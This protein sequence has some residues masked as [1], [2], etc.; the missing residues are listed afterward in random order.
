MLPFL[1]VMLSGILAFIKLQSS[2]WCLCFSLHNVHWLWDCSIINQQKKVFSDRYALKHQTEYWAEK[3]FTHWSFLNISKN[4]QP[5]NPPFPHFQTV[6]LFHLAKLRR[7]FVN[8]DS[9]AT[10]VNI[11][12]G[13]L[14]KG[15]P[16]HRLSLLLSGH[17][18]LPNVSQ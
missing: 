16:K 5:T 11:E 8:W 2:W 17:K 12:L 7:C 6:G 13:F 14:R 18:T 15:W 3:F 10:L 9:A 1:R 4:S